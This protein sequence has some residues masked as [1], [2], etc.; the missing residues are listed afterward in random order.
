MEVKTRLSSRRWVKAV[1]FIV[2]WVV[3]LLLLA[4]ISRMVSKRHST[5]LG[6]EVLEYGD[7]IQVV[8]AGSSHV[9]NGISPQQL[10]N[11]QGIRAQ[12]IASHGETMVCTYCHLRNALEYMKPKFVFVDLYGLSF[13]GRIYVNGDPRTWLDSL[14]LSRTKVETVLD[15]Y[16][17]EGISVLWP[18]TYEHTR[19]NSLEAEDVQP[20]QADPY[21]GA[22]RNCGFVPQQENRAVANGGETNE[23]GLEYLRRIVQLCR[24]KNVQLVPLILPY[25]FSNAPLENNLKAAEDLLRGE[26]L[27]ILDMRETGVVN[28]VTDY[29][30]YHHLNASG[31]DKATRLVGEW[32]A[33]Q[34]IANSREEDPGLA[35]KWNENYAVYRQLKRGQIQACTELE[36]LLVL[37][38]DPDYSCILSIP[39]R[40]CLWTDD[41][42]ADTRAQLEN[43]GIEL[44]GKENNTGL[45]AVVDSRNA[46]FSVQYGP[47]SLQTDWG[48]VEWQNR[49][50]GTDP[51]WPIF[52]LA[53]QEFAQYD[54]TMDMACAAGVLIVEN[55]SGNAIWYWDF[56]MET[57]L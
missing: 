10:W 9:L 49:A 18:F 46:A 24:E 41:S 38:H 19:W 50:E 39:P 3:F 27:E 2:F 53:G 20:V 34:G 33:G 48:Q 16:G 54:E 52:S 45:Y 31:M 15:L 43:L 4:G 7:E 12:T 14:P 13:E 25:A 40:L 51:L 36:D 55:Y 8:F 26:G 28:A 35:Q 11:E 23:L 17:W 32:L 29:A 47:D 42:Y 6:L 37:L 1:H 57:A 5:A 30:D 56:P 44:T 22:E 21:R